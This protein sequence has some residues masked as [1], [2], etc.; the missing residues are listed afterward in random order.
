VRDEIYCIA[1][2][3]LRNAYGHAHARTIEAEVRY[4]EGLLRVR[5]RDDGIGIKQTLLGEAGRTGHYG[6]KG[7]RERAEQLGAQLDVW[8][9]Q[10]AG[11][12]VELRVPERIA[13]HADLQG[14]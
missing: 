5:I 2:E 10:E 13:Y 4:E 14:A 12:E 3:A 9:Q 7:M 8:S 6:L 11:T 1:R